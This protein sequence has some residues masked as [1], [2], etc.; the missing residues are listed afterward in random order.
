MIAV[1]TLLNELYAS[2][3]TAQREG[4]QLVLDGP[5]SAFTEDFINK[6]RANK[7]ELLS[8]LEGKALFN[9]R[10]AIAERDGGYPLLAA[11]LIAFE[12]CLAQWLCANPPHCTDSSVC[13]HCG[14]P[15]EEGTVV[16]V[17]V[18]GDAGRRGALHTICAGRWRSLR[19]WE[20]KTTLI[21][22]LQP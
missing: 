16:P 18:V 8:C 6:L 20:G 17:T 7:Q 11:E 3:V 21:W 12:D 15:L 1:S 13:L 2:G 14:K 5:R 10:A 22:L 4:E 19:R 9:E